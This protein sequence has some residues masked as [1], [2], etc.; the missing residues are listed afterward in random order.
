[1]VRV[2]LISALVLVPITAFAQESYNLKIIWQKAA[3]EST[4][5]FGCFIAGEDINGDGYSDIFIC[6][7][8]IKAQ[9]SLGVV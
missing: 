3:P 1:V 9:D 8:S 7:D 6:A 4:L 2:F 5:A